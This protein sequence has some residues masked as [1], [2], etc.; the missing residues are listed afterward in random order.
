M[1]I[2][3]EFLFLTYETSNCLENIVTFLYH[4]SSLMHLDGSSM[5][6][7]L[8]SCEVSGLAISDPLT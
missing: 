4:T 1:R 3:I 8:G 7:P 2:I 6:F 5:M